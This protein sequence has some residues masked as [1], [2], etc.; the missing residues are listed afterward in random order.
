MDDQKTKIISNDRIADQIFR[1]RFKVDWASFIPGQFV[2]ISIPGDATF[3]RRPFGIASLNDG[4]AEIFYK[5]VGAGTRALSSI[6][7]ETSITV[8][9]PCGHG[10]QVDSLPTTS[11]LVAGGYGVSP[12]FGL[13]VKLLERGSDVQMFFGGMSAD[14]LFLLDELRALGVRLH[15]ATED[16]S[17]GTKG[18][19]TDLLLQEL[20][21]FASPH[22]FACGPDGL[23]KAVAEIGKQKGIA[24]QVSLERYMACGIG[25]CLGCACKNSDGKF[26]RTCR[27]GPVFDIND[28]EL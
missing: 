5:T 27:E 22:I 10:F 26:V 13:A 25:V 6:P 9:G 23:L 20:D 15:L 16:G 28:V 14:D 4:V 17:E 12:L 24:T 21:G 1:M 3:L 18:L 7:K 8:L 19:V 2:M 11:I